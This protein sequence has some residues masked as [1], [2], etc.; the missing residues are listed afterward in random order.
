MIDNQ[1]VLC[2]ANHYEAKYYFNPD[3]NHLPTGIKNEIKIMSVSF[4]GM[5]GGIF[6]IVFD[7]DKKINLAVDFLED[8]IMY[9]EISA[10]LK[11]KE[12]IREHQELLE[13]LELFYETF[14]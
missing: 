2:V 8:D 14:F 3:F 13:S 7:E 10:R 6:M 5:F 12:V 1:V 9:D 4:T 11:I